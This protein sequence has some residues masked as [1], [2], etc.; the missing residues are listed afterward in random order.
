M[1]SRYDEKNFRESHRQQVLIGS[2]HDLDAPAP[3]ILALLIPFRKTVSRQG[4]GLVQGRFE[5]G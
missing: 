5:I 4:D 1:S 2:V 3:P